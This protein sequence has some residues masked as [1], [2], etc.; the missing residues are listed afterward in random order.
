MERMEKIEVDLLDN[1]DIEDI[2][3][4]GFF[5]YTL[6]YTPSLS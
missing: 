5:N 2:N 3:Y 1:Q 6:A 4:Q